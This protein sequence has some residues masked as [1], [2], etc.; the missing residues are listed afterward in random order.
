MLDVTKPL[1]RFSTKHSCLCVVISYPSWF[2]QK[3]MLLFYLNSLVKRN[4]H[5][6]TILDLQEIYKYSSEKNNQ[7]LHGCSYIN[8]K[9]I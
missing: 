2:F 1:R 7:C 9:D 3:S 4:G 8:F 5:L 6:E